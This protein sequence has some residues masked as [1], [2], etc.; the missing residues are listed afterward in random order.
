M[1]V[2]RRTNPTDLELIDALAS[3]LREADRGAALRTL[4]ELLIESQLLENRQ[5]YE[6][7]DVAVYDEIGERLRGC[8]SDAFVYELI[9]IAQE[10]DPDFDSFLFPDG[11]AEIVLV[12]DRELYS[13]ADT[14]LERYLDYIS[15]Y[16]E[17]NLVHPSDYI[18]PKEENENK[19]WQRL[20]GNFSDMIRDWRDRFVIRL[21]E[22]CFKRVKAGKPQ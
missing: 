22:D 19:E 1:L 2:L 9:S 4:V 18:I 17:Y 11:R 21:I 8:Y 10:N 7:I 16:P 5:E 13:A 6:D 15:N 12:A 3:T 14:L 20:V